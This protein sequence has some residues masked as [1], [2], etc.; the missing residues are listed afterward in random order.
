M[1]VIVLQSTRQ[2]PADLVVMTFQSWAGILYAT[3]V[4][5]Q[6]GPVGSSIQ[7]WVL[8]NPHVATCNSH[9]AWKI[10]LTPALSTTRLSLIVRMFKLA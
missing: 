8:I 6:R 2:A 5:M 1:E 7:I 3:V 10:H 4:A 9:Q